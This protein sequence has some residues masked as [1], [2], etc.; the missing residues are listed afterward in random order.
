MNSLIILLRLL[1]E[2]LR[3]TINLYRREKSNKTIEEGFNEKDSD[4]LNNSL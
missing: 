3:D 1:A 4:K 2:M